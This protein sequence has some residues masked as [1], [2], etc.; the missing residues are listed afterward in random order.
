VQ[1]RLVKILEGPVERI[2]VA[3]PGSFGLV[4]DGASVE[5]DVTVRVHE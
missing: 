5:F 2:T 1:F 3:T 4:L